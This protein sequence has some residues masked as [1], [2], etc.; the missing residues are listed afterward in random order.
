MT[1]WS[2]EGGLKGEFFDRRLRLNLAAFLARYDDIQQTAL[3]NLATFSFALQNVG[4]A[5]VYGVEL[6]ST[7][8]ISDALTFFG[9]LSLQHDSYGKLDPTSIAAIND[10]KRLPSTRR[11]QGQIGFNYDQLLTDGPS[12]LRLLLGADAAYNGPY[13][14]TLDNSLRTVDYWLVNAY[15]GLA[16]G[17]NWDLRLN[18]RNLFNDKRVICCQTDSQ[19]LATTPPRRIMAELNFRY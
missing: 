13:F 11:V 17:E 18:A 7:L 1:V 6:E 16:F 12:A 10:A 14:S 9:Q 15:V 3:V 4:E 2:Y 5:E 8:A 19:V